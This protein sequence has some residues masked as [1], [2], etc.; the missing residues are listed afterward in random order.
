MRQPS[1]HFL[2]SDTITFTI[3]MRRKTNLLAPHYNFFKSLLELLKQGIYAKE[4][5]RT[6]I[7]LAPALTISN[8]QIDQ[9][10][11]GVREVIQKI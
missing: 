6:T 5:H 10:V 2:Y 8:K 11:D 9:L 7:R 4:T 1:Q 3:M